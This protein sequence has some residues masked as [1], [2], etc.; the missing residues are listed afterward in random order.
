VD[1]IAWEPSGAAFLVADQFTIFRL[2]VNVTRANGD[3]VLSCHWKFRAT[4]AG[5]CLLRPSLRT[6]RYNAHVLPPLRFE[7]SSAGVCDLDSIGT[8]DPWLWVGNLADGSVRRRSPKNVGIRAD[9]FDGPGGLADSGTTIESFLA[10]EVE[11]P[12]SRALREFCNSGNAA[13]GAPEPLMRYV[14][15]A[16]SRSLPMQRLEV[17]WAAQYGAFLSA[18]AVEAPPDGL[19]GATPRRRGVRLKHPTLGETI[20]KEADDP[21]V[22]FDAGWIPDPSDRDNFLEGVHIQAYYFQVRWFP[23][24]RWFTLRPPQGDFFIIGDR[25]VGWGVPDCLDAPPCCLRDQSAFFI[26]P[27]SR[28]LALFGRNNPAP[29]SVTP[30]QVNAILAGWSHEWVAGP[31][32]ECVTEAVRTRRPL[33][34]V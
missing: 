30:A 29:W 6:T 18:P 11:G 27:L 12:A 20:L 9:L 21:D 23:R 28:S 34:V 2:H 17:E 7:I 25:P 3:A 1:I 13:A 15:W 26:A 10:N 31:T 19:T 22:L 14:A 16:A 5:G 4:L 33:R 24:L 8:Q 32:S